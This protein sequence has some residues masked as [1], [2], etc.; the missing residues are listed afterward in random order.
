MAYKLKTFS[1]S[2]V[3]EP[4]AFPVGA[5]TRSAED[6]ERVARSIYSTLDADKE[7]FVLLSLNNKNRINGFKIISTGSLTASLV[8]PREVYRAA[9]GLCAAAVIFVHNHPSGEPAPSQEDTELTRRLKESGE[10]LGIRVLDHIVL[11]DGRYYSFSN[12]ALL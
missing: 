11:G 5:P 2:L 7:H 12:S 8:H 6:A 3:C 9:L 10:I 1:V 4:E